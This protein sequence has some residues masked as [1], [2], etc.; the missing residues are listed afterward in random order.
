M[1]VD[2]LVKEADRLSKRISKTEQ[3]MRSSELDLD[4]FWN[5]N[6]VI[7]KQIRL[8]LR[9]TPNLDQVD[10]ADELNLDLE[11]VCRICGELL[12]EN[13]IKSIPY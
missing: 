12:S 10:I 11:L 9:Q 13:K 4:N 2:L 8:L 1:T 6:K 3:I 5:P 7:E